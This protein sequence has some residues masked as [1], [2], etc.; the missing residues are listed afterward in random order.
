[1]IFNFKLG[2]IVRFPPLAK[3]PTVAPAVDG[4]PGQFVQAPERRDSWKAPGSL[5]EQR[6]LRVTNDDLQVGWDP[7]RDLDPGLGP[8]MFVDLPMNTMVIIP[9]LSLYQRV[10]ITQLGRF[11]LQRFVVVM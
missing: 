4:R 11:H 10:N 6:L 3:L 7:N 9:K 2:E 1:M 5:E 8:L